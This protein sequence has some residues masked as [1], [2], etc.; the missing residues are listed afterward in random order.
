[1]ALVGLEVCAMISKARNDVMTDRIE[2]A[3]NSSSRISLPMVTAGGNV[4]LWKQMGG[5]TDQVG[6]RVDGRRVTRSWS[7]GVPPR[8]ELAERN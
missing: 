8:D 3:L 5:K 7:L 2:I 1:M 6:R 4:L